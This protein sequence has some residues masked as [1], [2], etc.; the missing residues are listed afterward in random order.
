[1]EYMLILEKGASPN[2]ERKLS[3]A[4]TP[5]P[6]NQQFDVTYEKEIQSLLETKKL[7]NKTKIIGVF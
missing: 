6:I 3:H 2:K 7:N 5:T 1:M 4:H